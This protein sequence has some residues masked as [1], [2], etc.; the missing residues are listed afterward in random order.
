MPITIGQLN[1]W[2]RSLVASSRWQ[3]DE[4]GWLHQ[5]V[6]HSLMGEGSESTE[7]EERVARA[8]GGALDT[9]FD[10]GTPGW[11]LWW[12]SSGGGGGASV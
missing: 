2:S 4:R 1:V 5:H 9:P 10:I 6:L 3:E 8:Q 7:E 11:W 12:S